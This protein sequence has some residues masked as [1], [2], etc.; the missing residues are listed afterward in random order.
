MTPAEAQKILHL[1]L[2]SD[3]PFLGGKALEFALFKVCHATLVDLEGRSSL[4]LAQTYGIPSISEVL[5]GT[6]EF[7]ASDKAGRR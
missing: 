4:L 3:L 1:G 7:E 6:S 2:T 5:K